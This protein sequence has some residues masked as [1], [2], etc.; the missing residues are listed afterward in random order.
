MNISKETLIIESNRTGF[1]AEILE[2]VIRLIDLL[3][4]LT[5][6]EFLHSR[7]ALKGGTALNLF[8]FDLPRLS[9]DIDLNYIG[10]VGRTI[11]LEEKPLILSAIDKICREKKYHT[12]RQPSEHAG[13][14]WTI[15]YKK[16]IYKKKKKKKNIFF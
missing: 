5:N 11:M 2:K 16:E 12:I 13:G 15:C 8:H 4:T 3:N 6:D 7:I 10:S 14:K 1:R 9:V